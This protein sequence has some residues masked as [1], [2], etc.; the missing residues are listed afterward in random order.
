LSFPR[1]VLLAAALVASLAVA[2]C[3]SDEAKPHSAVFVA[4]PWQAA[5]VLRY[6]LT[7]KGVDNEA[8]CTLKIDPARDGQAT[9]SRLCSDNRGNKDDGVAT[10]DNATLAPKTSTRT[11]FA[12][13][14]NRTTTHTV[15][16][17]GAQATFETTSGGKTR[18]TTRDLPAVTEAVPEPAWYDDESLLW[19]VRGIKLEEGY[20]ATYTHVINAG[21]PRALSVDVSVHATENIEVPAGKFTT[22]RI[23]I[24]RESSVYTVWVDVASPHRVVR[25]LIEDSTYE[26][27]SIE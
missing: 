15:A 8:A 13:E 5:E 21:R 19:L 14:A 25:A 7:Q 10:V 26:L 20:E 23:R 24:S 1:P 12:A 27:V 17:D 2:A 22:W 6:D 4:P 16:Y 18:T 9:L 11:T 3:G